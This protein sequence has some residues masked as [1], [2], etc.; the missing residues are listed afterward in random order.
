MNLLTR[1]R[2]LLHR[3]APEGEIDEE[4]YSHIQHRADDLERSGLPRAEAERR[5][6]VEFG[7]YVHF[8]QESHKEIGSLWFETLAQ[9]SRYGLRMLRKSPGFTLAAVL[10]LALG[11]G[12]NAIVFSIVNALILR[13][14][15][16]PN[17]QGLYMIENGHSPQQSYPDYLDLRDRNRSFDGMTIADIAPVGLDVDGKASSTWANEVSGNYF[18]VLGVQPYLGRLLHSSDEHG[19]N[20]SPYIV[21]SYGFWNG[22]FHAD[23]NVAGRVV[24][25]NKHPYTILGVAPPGFNGTELFFNADFWVPMVD[26]QQIEGSSDLNNRGGRGMWIVGH[27][28]P[29]VQ[30][31]QATADVNAV[32]AYLAKTYP[33]EDSGLAFSLA[34]PGLMGDMLGGPVRAF[35]AGLT[36][37][38]GLILLAACANLGS[39][40]AARAADRAREIALRLALGSSR[41]RILRQLLVEAVIVSLIGGAVGLAGSVSLLRWLSTWRPVQNFPINLPVSPDA[42]VYGVA[43]LLALLSGILFGV[44]PVRQVLR[45]N[46]WHVVKSGATA[47]AGRRITVRDVLLVMQIVVCAVLVTASLVAVRGLA[48]SLHSNFGFQPQNVMLLNTDLDMADYSGERVAIMQKKLLDTVSGIPGVDSVGLS[49]RVPLGLGWSTDMIFRDNI[50]D[51]KASTKTAEA[52]Y[53]NVSPGYFQ[54]AGTSLLSGRGFTQHDDAKTPRV[55]V[56]NREFARIVFGSEANAVGGYYKLFGGSRIQVV[57]LVEDGK[58]KTITE[59]PQPAMFFPILQSPTSATWL[60]V[61]SNRDPQSLATALEST[62]H[63]LDPGLPFSVLTWQKELGSALFASRAATISLGVLGLLGAMLAV[64]GIFGMASYSVSKRLRELGIR[65]AL[66]AQRREVLGAALGRAIRLLAFGSV[67]GLL[68]GLAATRVLSALVYQA[69]PRD[70]LVLAGAVLTMLVLGLVAT[71]IPAS[72]ALRADPLALLREE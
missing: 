8:Q 27:A 37:L 61:R 70:P 25:V 33:K 38:S 31:A 40:F 71:W 34:R 39:L 26:Q 42:R 59:D 53:Y 68:L 56:V 21:L 14:L 19:P 52:M 66:G 22:G 60:V 72:R 57:G 24:Q 63:S 17:A 62:V 9:D 13:P 35:L 30:P 55:A 69:T 67:T 11:I 32:A 64:T 7:G 49:D 29:G 6:R 58:Y 3:S 20:G 47:A 54:A 43:L 12:A 44:V 10:T 1:L 28:K 45:A 5:A 41:A 50:T 2:S 46:P 23:P 15:N 48:R 16:V 4:L 18:D 51:L 36:L 65:I